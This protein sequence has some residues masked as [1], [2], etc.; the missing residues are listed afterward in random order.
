MEHTKISVEEIEVFKNLKDLQVIFDVGARTD[1]EYLDIYPNAEYHLFEPNP[2]FFAQLKE[3]VGDRENVHLNI[4]GLGD[5]EGTFEYN[6]FY[7]AFHGGEAPIEGSH[8][9]L[10][11]KT[12]DWYIKENN[13]KRIDFLK[14]DTEGY[15]YKV[16]L[17]GKEAV[18]L[19]K[20]IQYEHWDDLQEFHDL[21]DSQFDMEYIGYRN[22]LCT[23]K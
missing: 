3:R 19:A 18:K 4:Y 17:G 22:V 8:Q 14:I 23:R 13:I 7:Q 12:L 10:P 9:I 1:V 20:Y 11:I 6:N 5:I 21:L 16:L 15:D 2:E